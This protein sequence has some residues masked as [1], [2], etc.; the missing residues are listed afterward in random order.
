[1]FERIT[2]EIENLLYPDLRPYGKPPLNL[3]DAS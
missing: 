1:M 2:E 3:L